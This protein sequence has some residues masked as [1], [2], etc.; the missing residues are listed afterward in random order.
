MIEVKIKMW[1]S[2]C[3]KHA[4]VQI[5]KRKMNECSLL[6]GYIRPK[7]FTTD[8]EPAVP[9]LV[10]D[11]SFDNPCHFT[12]LLSFEDALDVCNFFN[13]WVGDT[14]DFA[15]LFGCH[16]WVSDE[17][18]FV[19]SLLVLWF[20]LCV[21]VIG[22]DCSHGVITFESIVIQIWKFGGVDRIWCIVLGFIHTVSIL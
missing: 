2:S 6:V 15:L 5:I 3:S 1:L 17:D 20:F 4:Y 9:Q 22:V 8:Y 7:I 14:D 16:I 10:L 11:L 18:F 13:G 12:V 21:V 19:V